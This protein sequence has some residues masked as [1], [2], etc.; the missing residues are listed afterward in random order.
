MERAISIDGSYQQ[1]PHAY[2]PIYTGYYFHVNLF[3]YKKQTGNLDR[4]DIAESIG[5]EALAQQEEGS[6][7]IE[8]SVAPGAFGGDVEGR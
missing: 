5:T 7:E 8:V 4:K 6:G 2:Y 1:T 3:Q